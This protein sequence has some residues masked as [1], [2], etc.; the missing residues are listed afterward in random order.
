M[1]ETTIA[2]AMIYSSSMERVA[3]LIVALA[4]ILIMVGVF[5]YVIGLVFPRS[6]RYRR[7]I[8]DLYI[9]AKIKQIADKE[10]VSIDSEL[11]LI[12]KMGSR[13]RTF[14]KVLEE[15]LNEKL[16]EDIEEKEEKK[17]K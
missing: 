14:D 11:K 4:I 15:K 6:E 7:L 12:S 1:Y 17:K 13:G 10:D 9:T 2:E 8:S 5:L 3:S 16:L